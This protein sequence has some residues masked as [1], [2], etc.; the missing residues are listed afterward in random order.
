MYYLEES[1]QI[2]LEMICM[3]FSLGKGGSPAKEKKKER[4]KIN[5]NLGKADYKENCMKA[6]SPLLWLTLT[7]KCKKFINGCWNASPNKKG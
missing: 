7:I 6:Y 5:K 2:Q 1:T 3:L 4:K